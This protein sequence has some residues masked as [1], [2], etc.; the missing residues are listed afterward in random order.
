MPESKRLRKARKHLQDIQDAEEYADLMKLA[1]A[2]LDD[3]PGRLFRGLV[4][5]IRQ[6]P[7]TTN[8][9]PK[10]TLEQELQLSFLAAGPDSLFDPPKVYVIQSGAVLTVVRRSPLEVTIVQ[11]G[12]D[13]IQTI[14]VKYQRDKQWR[15]T[16]DT[17]KVNRV[18]RAGYRV[19]GHGPD[20]S[21]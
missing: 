14:V 5:S 11:E 21:R 15:V 16:T 19:R 4:E 18:S 13:G 2:L 20:R 6:R 12:T 1:G 7:S 9:L 8:K 10:I 17:S 3:E